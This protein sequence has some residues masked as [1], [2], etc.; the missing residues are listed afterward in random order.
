MLNGVQLSLCPTVL[1]PAF[2]LVVAKLYQSTV[3][4][5]K[6]SLVY[7]Q[8]TSPRPLSFSPH[9]SLS[10]QKQIHQH[11]PSRYH[12]HPPNRITIIQNVFQLQGHPL[13]RHVCSP[14]SDP[15]HM[16]RA[17]RH[18]PRRSCCRWY[19]LQE[20]TPRLLRRSL[21]QRLY[22]KRTLGRSL[23]SHLRVRQK[24]RT[25][26]S[27]SRLVPFTSSWLTYLCN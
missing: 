15:T 18:Q 20:A 19:T 6:C 22:L 21:Q 13:R 4:M 2:V 9:H 25:I 1:L 3:P 8:P 10:R 5:K 17:S 23:H 27:L 11:N 26:N 14:R 16:R 7:K 24:A 12:D